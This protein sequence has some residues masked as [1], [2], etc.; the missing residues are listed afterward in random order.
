MKYYENPG[1]FVSEWRDDVKAVVDTVLDFGL[2]LEEF[3]EAVMIKGMAQAKSRGGVAWIVD[4]S[5][6]TGVFSQD[7][8][9]YIGSDVFP[10]FAANGIKYFITINSEVSALTKMTVRTFQAK[11]GP[12]GIQL[13]E[14]KSVED[15]ITWLKEN[16]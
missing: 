4:S 6:A 3:K 10:A 13:V 15:A 2:T 16:A 12:H 5:Q 1:K 8:Q 7:I 11:T 9:D 14:V